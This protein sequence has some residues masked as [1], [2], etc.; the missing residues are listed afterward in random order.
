[1]ISQNTSYKK[2]SPVKGI[3]PNCNP[4]YAGLLLNKKKLLT[5]TIKHKLGKSLGVSK[6][7]RICSINK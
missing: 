4:F 3:I 5:K 6:P 2:P 7:W 1:M